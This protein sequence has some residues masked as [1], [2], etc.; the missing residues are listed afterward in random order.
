MNM[1]IA[2]G[3]TPQQANNA[4]LPKKFHVVGNKFG[5]AALIGSVGEH[6]AFRIYSRAPRV[7]FRGVRQLSNQGDKP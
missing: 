1:E 2:R 6:H 5:L 4:A 3:M 7:E